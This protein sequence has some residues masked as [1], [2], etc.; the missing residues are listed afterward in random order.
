MKYLKILVSLVILISL[1]LPHS[2]SASSSNS[3]LKKEVANHSSMIINSL[4]TGEAIGER[5]FDT[6]T[7]SIY[8]DN[9]ELKE[10]IMETKTTT[11]NWI[12]G[13]E[14]ETNDTDRY[15]FDNGSLSSVNGVET[16]DQQFSDSLTDFSQSGVS[17]LAHS[18]GLSYATYYSQS[19]RG[20]YFLNS[21]KMAGFV[22][23]GFNGLLLDPKAAVPG[24]MITKHN[25]L[26]GNQG[27]LVS[28]FQIRADAV[29]SARLELL[30][31]A[32]VLSGSGIALLTPAFWAGVASGGGAAWL[33][34]KVYNSAMADID[35][36]YEIIKKIQTQ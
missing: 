29:S 22:D 34:I 10:I 32:A 15:I 14:T 36:A 31:A 8:D 27:G 13:E 1:F 33:M 4:E 18:G 25:Y 19:S 26:Q 7:T 3:E 20:G 9:N 2:A 30:G 16:S 5:F 21:G 11:V 28:S 24:T 12:T 35:A 23:A 6:I 17:T